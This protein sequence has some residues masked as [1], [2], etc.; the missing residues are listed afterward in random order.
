[1]LQI[2]PFRMSIMYMKLV[3]ICSFHPV[4]ASLFSSKGTIDDKSTQLL[5]CILQAWMTSLSADRTLS[6]SLHQKID[7][8]SFTHKLVLVKDL[9]TAWIK[10]GPNLW[11]G[12]CSG[13]SI[14]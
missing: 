13:L 3:R 8:V 14:H 2:D 6:E 10:F 5:N 12:S 11:E 9:Y 1:M 7:A 4:N